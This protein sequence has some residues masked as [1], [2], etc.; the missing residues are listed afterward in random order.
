MCV[1]VQKALFFFLFFEVYKLAEAEKYVAGNFH[2]ALKKPQNSL[3]FF[4]GVKKGK[5]ILNNVLVIGMA[6]RR[7]LPKPESRNRT[8]INPAVCHHFSISAATPLRQEVTK[9]ASRRQIHAWMAFNPLIIFSVD[10]R[11]SAPKFC[12]DA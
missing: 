5:K 2:I 7:A 4:Q 11:I 12:S 9:F 1:R 8:R 10:I 3:F 6:N